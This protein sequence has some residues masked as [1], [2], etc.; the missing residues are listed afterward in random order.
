MS[1]E[2]KEQDDINLSLGT[3]KMS[4]L[5][6]TI[7]MPSIL[8]MLIIGVQGMVD[9]LFLG[10]FV[11]PNAMASVNIATPYNQVST[12]VSLI[13]SI[14]GT[15]YIG[16]MLGAENIKIAQD[17][18]K[19]SFITLLISGIVI[20][21]IAVSFN[22]QLAVMLGA[23]EILLEDSS[24]YIK[25]TAL[26]MPFLLMYFL[27]SYT[28]RII[29]RPELFFMGSIAS[30]VCNLILNY[31]LIAKLQL[32]VVGASLAT[33]TAYTVGFIINITPVL[34]RKN[35]VN[36]FVGEFN[37]KILGK[38][39]YNGSSEGITAIAMA[40]TTFVFNLTFM[41]YYGASGVSAFTIISYITQLT[42]MIIFG[43]VDGTS[44][45]VSFNYGA[46]LHSRV[47]EIIKI[48]VVANLIIGV[49]AYVSVYFFG[50]TLVGFFA[51][52]D[53]ELIELTYEG[54][55]VNSLAFL[56][57]GINILA[58]SYYTAIGE[59]LKS[60][61]ISS[62]RGLTFIIIGIFTLPRIMGVDGVWLVAPFADFM[63]LIVLGVVMFRDK[64]KALK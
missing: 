3:E 46:G 49:V 61:V 34:N 55:K 26:Y 37:W 6:M 63:T 57:L 11:G 14:G 15:A 27:V 35:I 45:I 25:I 62:S 44:P 20:M 40:V 52:G 58:S 28:N 29:G 42:N 51:G 50:A 13:I 24:T 7:V 2:S 48:C 47:K 54:A 17:I 56:I 12:S 5:F 38:V 59:A 18:F 53:T 33:G 9:G 31:V 22:E 32:G 30:I 21:I 39:C 43:V 19:T 64:K 23:D 16:R 41:H 10:N 60:V 1:E 4:K 8:A 36:I